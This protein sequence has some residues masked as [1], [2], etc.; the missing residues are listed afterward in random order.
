[1]A[2]IILAVHNEMAMIALLGYEGHNVIAP[3]LPCPRDNGDGNGNGDGNDD[4]VVGCTQA[5]T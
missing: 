1:M 3:V 2:P 5:P 4:T